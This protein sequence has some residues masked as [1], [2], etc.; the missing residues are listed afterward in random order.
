[1]GTVSGSTLNEAIRLQK[2]SI[3]LLITKQCNN[4]KSLKLS[5]LA[6]LSL[7]VSHLHLPNVVGLALKEN[8]YGA[9]SLPARLSLWHTYYFSSDAL[10]EIVGQSHLGASEMATL[11]VAQHLLES[12]RKLLHSTG[13]DIVQIIDSP[14]ACARRRL[15]WRRWQ[16]CWC[17]CCHLQH[18]GHVGSRAADVTTIEH[19]K[20]GGHSCWGGLSSGCCCCCSCTSS[21]CWWCGGGGGEETR[22]RLVECLMLTHVQYWR[23]MSIHNIYVHD[24]HVHNVHV[25]HV[26][27]SC[28]CWRSWNCCWCSQRTRPVCKGRIAKKGNKFSHQTSTGRWNKTTKRTRRRKE[29]RKENKTQTA[30]KKKKTAD[31]CAATGKRVDCNHSL[32]LPLLTLLLAQA[33]IH[34][35]N[36]CAGLATHS[37]LPECARGADGGDMKSPGN[38]SWKISRSLLPPLPPL[39]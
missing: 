3:I 27:Y 38:N 32:P 12:L 7:L 6:D 24:I 20:T 11:G 4:N 36:C 10:R 15:Q 28:S 34:T 23:R 31:V 1:M 14:K 5:L 13:T 18:I 22:S 9:S 37:M 19:I 35:H 17:R 26:G 29:K 33:R 30:R 16:R 8:E 39:L 21:G 25:S 2:E